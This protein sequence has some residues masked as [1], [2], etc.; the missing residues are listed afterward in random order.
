MFNFTI[1][2]IPTPA[3]VSF[4]PVD[5]AFENAVKKSIEKYFVGVEIYMEKDI[6]TRFGSYMTG[7]DICLVYSGKI[8]GLKLKQTDTKSNVKDISHFLFCCCKL[9]RLSPQF[10]V[11]KIFTSSQPPTKPSID[12]L[13]DEHVHVACNYNQELLLQQVLTIINNILTN[14]P[15]FV[16]QPDPNRMDVC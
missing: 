2:T 12:L 9:A 10:T 8:I 13:S 1:P 14:V 4:I 11:Y 3:A 16:Q 15:G 6:S 5:S 7:I